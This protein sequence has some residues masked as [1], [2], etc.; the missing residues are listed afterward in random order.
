[1]I[2]FPKK[3]ALFAVGFVSIALMLFVYFNYKA[4]HKDLILAC[5]NF[6]VF[7]YDNSNLMHLKKNIH[8]YLYADNSG[9]RTEKGIIDNEK[10]GDRYFLDRD[11]ILR[12]TE[13]RKIVIFEHQKLIKRPHDNAPDG[14]WGAEYTPEIM[15]HITI[16][17]IS[18]D[19]FLFK[20]R[21]SPIAICHSHI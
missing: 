3:P 20:E 17:E 6:N 19:L 21:S 1:M 10:T 16:T 14:I 5:D 8:L 7:I 4:K 12:H 15:Q 11:I 13:K 9:L 18:P 2:K